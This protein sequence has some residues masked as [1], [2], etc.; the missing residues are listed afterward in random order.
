I[1]ETIQQ[2]VADIEEAKTNMG[3]DNPKAQEL[4]S[5]FKSGSK[6][7]SKEMAYIREHALGMVAYI[8]R[9]MKEREITELAMKMAPTKTDVQLVAFRASKQIEKHK[10]PEERIV[11]AK[12]LA[13]AKYKYEET[14]D[15]KK[16]PNTPLEIRKKPEKTRSNHP[17]Q[18]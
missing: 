9:I 14:E 11:R 18:K 7:T 17:E 1:K 12:H 5:K 2:Y 13:D 3:E 6:L 16:K 15:Y 8:D 10:E 4:I